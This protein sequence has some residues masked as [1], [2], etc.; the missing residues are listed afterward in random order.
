MNNSSFFCNDSPV[1]RSILGLSENID[2]NEGHSFEKMLMS[3]RG[4]L[5]KVH[6]KKSSDLIQIMKNVLLILDQMKQKSEQFC[7]MNKQLWLTADDILAIISHILAGKNNK[8]KR[9]KNL[10]KK[11]SLCSY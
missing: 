2:E 4:K 1:R 5:K 9:H 3:C 11:H 7:E 8:Q 6:R 10:K